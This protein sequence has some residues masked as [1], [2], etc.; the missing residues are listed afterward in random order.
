MTV[1]RNIAVLCAA[2]AVCAG[3]LTPAMATDPNG[4]CIPANGCSKDQQRIRNGRWSQCGGTCR[5]RNPVAVR[6]M[7]ATLYDAQCST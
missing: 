4:W 1:L 3:A 5:L 6:D 2:L 7:T